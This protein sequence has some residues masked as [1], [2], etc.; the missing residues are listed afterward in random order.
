MK[1][2][3]T[4]GVFDLFH[5]GHLTLLQNASALCD[6]LVVGVSTDELLLSE[7][8]KHSVIPLHERMEIVRAISHVDAVVAQDHMDKMAM[9]ERLRFDV[10][11]VGDDWFNTPR[12]REL[13]TCFEDVGVKIV[14]FPYTKGTSSTLINQVLE[15]RR[16]AL[17]GGPIRPDVLNRPITL[18]S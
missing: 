10:M 17:R 15:E 18:A 3:Y 5:I 14:Y 16:A 11:F 6:R 2:G 4:T 8:G 7:K 13:A 1:L 9:W 12:W